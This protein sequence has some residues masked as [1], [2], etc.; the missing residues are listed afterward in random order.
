MHM[1]PPV[2]VALLAVLLAAASPAV[3]QDYPA[4]TVRL[5][6][7]LSAGSSSD[8]MIRIVAEKL[9]QKWGQSVIVENR[10]GAGGNIAAD[11]VANAAPDGYTLLLSNNSIAIAPSFYK[12]LNYD[13]MKD[14]VPVTQ[15]SSVPHILCVTPSLKVNSVRDVVALAKAE[16]SKLNFSSAGMGQTDHMAMQLFADLTGIR[17]THIPYKGGPPALFA[18]VSGEVAMDF[19]GLT[20]AMPLMKAGKIRCLAVSTNKRSEAVP[21]MPTMD[22][23]GVKGYDHTLWNGVFAPA[24]T[25]QPII[26]KIAEGFAGVL[27]TPEMKKRLAEL[28]AEPIGTSPAEFNNYFLAEVKKWAKVTK[29]T[30]IAAN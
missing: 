19:P 30:G 28:G 22:E 20:V 8:T 26:A 10:P 12:N 14:L 11:E 16:P 2:V 21:N 24:G 9:R 6:F 3:A 23:E 4:R 27:R 7:G 13:P 15:V 1:K 25:P 29:A 5:I 17:M 18:V